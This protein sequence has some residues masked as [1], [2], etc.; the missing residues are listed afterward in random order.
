MLLLRLHEE[1]RGTDSTSEREEGHDSREAED[2]GSKLKGAL[3]QSTRAARASGP[4]PGPRPAVAGRRESLG[5]LLVQCGT[6]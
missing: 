5:S 6:K 1:E 4:G 2:K 3:R